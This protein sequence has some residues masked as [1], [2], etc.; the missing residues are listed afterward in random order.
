[1]RAVANG[2]VVS[3]DGTFLTLYTKYYLPK[4][5]YNIYRYKSY[6]YESIRIRLLKHKNIFY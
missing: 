6:S 4:H 5:K 2:F 1:M 3:N